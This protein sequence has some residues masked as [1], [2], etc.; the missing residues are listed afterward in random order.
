MF[1]VQLTRL[2]SKI[3]ESILFQ[4]CKNTKDQMSSN[5]QPGANGKMDI[6]PVVQQMRSAVRPLEAGTHF[7]NKWT[8]SLC[9]FSW[10]GGILNII[11]SDI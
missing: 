7:E 11:P 10:G 4:G 2:G 6:L 9:F 3:H 5:M 1:V 8:Q